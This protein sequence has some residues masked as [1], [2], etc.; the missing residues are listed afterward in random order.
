[1]PLLKS[2]QATMHAYMSLHAV[3][4]NL[5]FLLAVTFVV[6]F[7]KL[8]VCKQKTKTIDDSAVETNC[9]DVNFSPYDALTFLKRFASTFFLLFSP[10]R[11]QIQL[12]VKSF[13]KIELSQMPPF[14]KHGS[15]WLDNLKH[16]L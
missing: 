10:M 1:M 13:L 7:S 14:S 11:G 5:S 4:L 2:S 9:M 8:C 16:A 12:F 15:D 6:V 3:T